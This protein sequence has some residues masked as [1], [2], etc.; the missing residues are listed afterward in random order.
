MGAEQKRILVVDDE[1][2]IRELLFEMLQR[3]SYTVETAPTGK[4]ALQ[5]A[6][7]KAYDLIVSDIRLPDVSGMKILDRLKKKQPDLGIILIT[8]YGSIKNAVRAMKQGAFDYITKPFDLDEIELVID[9]YFEYQNLVVENQYL[10][11]ELDRKFSFENIVGASDPMQRVFDSI[12]MVARSRATVLIQG[13]SGTGKELVA[14]A[15]HYN[16]DRKHRAFITTNCA[17]LPEGLVESE[18][19]G[20]E[21]G[22]FTGAYRTN[23]GRFEMADGGTILLDEVS[24]I[25]LPLQAKLLRVIQEREIERVGGGKLIPVDVRIIA[26]T[27]RNL[28]EEV[29]KDNFRADLFYRLNVVPIYLPPLSERR[30]DIPLLIKYFV[31]KFAAENGSPLKSVCEEAMH[32]LTERDWPGNVREV[33][34]AVE[35]AVVMSGPDVNNLES[36]HFFFSDQS[37]AASSFKMETGQMTLHDMEKNLIL[38]TL[39]ENADNRTK[40]AEILGISVRTLRNKLNEYRADGITV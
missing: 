28:K 19:F 31:H 23:I 25:S 24:E 15:I 33:E 35:R 5:M 39:R 30:E 1:D 17:A 34:N 12:R 26:T 21:K 11:S 9:K 6:E 38:K 29:E 40:T 22:A 13:S 27:N 3:K 10:R 8:A 20:H 7:E 4:A 16:S 32:M 37:E 18:L 2:V 14:R 36:K